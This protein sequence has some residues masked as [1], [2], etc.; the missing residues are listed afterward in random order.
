MLILL[1]NV[2]R[3]IK[4]DVI[5]KLR[6]GDA[7]YLDTYADGLKDLFAFCTDEQLLDNEQF[8]EILESDL[9]ENHKTSIHHIELLNGQVTNMIRKRARG[10]RT[11]HVGRQAVL[12]QLR[13]VRS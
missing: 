11:V 4:L 5:R 1:P 8:L 9:I 12:Q 6:A 7:D 2:P 10:R 13:K 3:C